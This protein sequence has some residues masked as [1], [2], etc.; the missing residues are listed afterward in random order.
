MISRP[1]DAVYLTNLV[2]SVVFRDLLD[3]SLIENREGAL[4]LLKLLAHQI[5][6]LVNYTELSTRLG[7][8]VKTIKQYINLFEQS[9]IVFKICLTR[10][11]NGRNWQ[12]AQ[13]LFLRS[14][15]ATPLLK[16]FSR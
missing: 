15:R 3:L 10:P 9:F 4:N 16:I 13:D 1:A 6:S 12:D 14:G 11:K 8:E 5:G 2:D 7:L